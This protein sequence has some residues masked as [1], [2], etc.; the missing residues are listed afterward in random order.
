MPLVANAASCLLN[1]VA[2]RRFALGHPLLRSRSPRLALGAFRLHRPLARPHRRRRLGAEERIAAEEPLKHLLLE[3][4]FS[5]V[6]FKALLADADGTG[7]DV[8]LAP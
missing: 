2:T 1:F 8:Q 4:I 7:M 6:A 3:Q 5:V